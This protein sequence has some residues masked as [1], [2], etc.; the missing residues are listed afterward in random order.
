MICSSGHIWLL[1]NTLTSLW[2]MLV[3]LRTN[4][5][6]TSISSVYSRSSTHSFEFCR[7]THRHLPLHS[8]ALAYSRPD[9]LTALLLTSLL[10]LCDWSW[11]RS[12]VAQAPACSSW[13]M[14]DSSL[15]SFPSEPI[16]LHDGCVWRLKVVGTLVFLT[17]S[18]WLIAAGGVCPFNY[19]PEPLIRFTP[20][21]KTVLSRLWSFW[22]I[23][24]ENIYS[25]EFPFIPQRGI[26]I[27]GTFA[28]FMFFFSI[29]EK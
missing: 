16:R 20:V 22:T 15:G 18:L 12:P 3:L 10:G 7:N 19:Q 6:R 11:F 5:S 26:F 17:S 2:M 27:F 1:S 28:L 29:E 21:R 24:I 14:S 25:F 8:W 13:L 23:K 4:L 9:D